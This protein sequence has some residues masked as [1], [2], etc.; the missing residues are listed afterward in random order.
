MASYIKITGGSGS[1]PRILMAFEDKD[2]KDKS[3]I[4]VK[5]ATQDVG[6]LDVQELPPLGSLQL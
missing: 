4:E 2:D 5:R 6:S 1:K 3:D